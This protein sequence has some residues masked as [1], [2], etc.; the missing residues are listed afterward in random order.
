MPTSK[1]KVKTLLDS[2]FNRWVKTIDDETLRQDIQ[3]GSIIT[4]G[5][6]TSMLLDEP[7]NDY[8]IYFNSYDLAYRV[9]EFYLNKYSNKF[10][11]THEVKLCQIGKSEPG[12]VE[13]FNT[14]T[15]PEYGRPYFVIKS[16]GIITAK[17]TEDK[18]YEYFEQ[19]DGDEDATSAAN[20][21]SS[22]AIKHKVPTAKPGFEPR[23]QYL[24]LCFTENAITVS[25]D[26]QL[27]LRFAGDPAE[28]HKNFDFVHCQCYWQSWDNQLFLPQRALE[29][30]ITRELKYTGS[31]FPLAS[32][33]RLRKFIRRGWT[34][35]AGQILKM[36]MQCQALDLNDIQ[37]LRCQLISVDVAYF[38]ELIDKLEHQQ[39]LNGS[40]PYEVSTYITHLIDEIFGD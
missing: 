39:K 7:V 23:E 35:N 4:G 29:S 32:V 36:I 1:L 26:I 3:K 6:I 21:L 20:F 33:F 37:V 11:T 15:T 34:I 13:E 38:M 2:K 40:E 25:D 17:N 9:A 10:N 24:P 16:A 12:A 28:V 22:L 30:I 18:K 14:P 8:D 27:I 19:Y 5:A 31:L